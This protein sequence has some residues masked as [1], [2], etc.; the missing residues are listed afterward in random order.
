MLQINCPSWFKDA[1]CVG[2]DELFFSTAPSKRK[3][4]ASICNNLCKNKD[5]CRTMAVES[6]LTI[7]VWGGLTGPELTRFIE[8]TNNAVRSGQ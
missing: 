4:A 3:Q 1:P 8:S 7:G 2:K 6:N 5:E